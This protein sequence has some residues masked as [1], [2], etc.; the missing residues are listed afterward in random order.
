VRVRI[1]V[2]LGRISD[3]PCVAVRLREKYNMYTANVGC[4]SCSDTATTRGPT[5]QLSMLAIHMTALPFCVESSFR[6]WPDLS[7]KCGSTVVSSIRKYSPLSN[8]TIA[9]KPKV[10]KGCIGTSNRQINKK[11]APQA[12]SRSPPPD[13]AN[14]CTRNSPRKPESH[15][16]RVPKTKMCSVAGCRLS[17]PFECYT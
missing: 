15:G 13:T 14:S 11:S 1:D 7:A 17:S 6:R 8:K 10:S 3:I 5:C 9:P 4:H 2:Q 12:Y 16:W